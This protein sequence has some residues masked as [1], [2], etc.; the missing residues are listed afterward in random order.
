MTDEEWIDLLPD[1]VVHV[2]LVV[3]RFVDVAC[4]VATIFQRVSMR[5]SRAIPIFRCL[6]NA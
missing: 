2:W 1:Y 3:E 4:D 5:V 6:E